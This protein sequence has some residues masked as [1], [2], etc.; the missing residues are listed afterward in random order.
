M[1]SKYKSATRNW[2]FMAILSSIKNNVKKDDDG[3]ILSYDGYFMNL[4][5]GLFSIKKDY[6][7]KTKILK[8]GQTVEEKLITIDPTEFVEFVFGKGY[9]PD[10]VVTFESAYSIME[11][12]DFKWRKNIDL[13]KKNLKKFLER[14]SLKVPTEI[15]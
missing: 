15:E 12:S 6:H 3:N 7:G 9:R 2:L 5:K 1:K 8:H 4:N 13:I 11:N 10:D 14:A